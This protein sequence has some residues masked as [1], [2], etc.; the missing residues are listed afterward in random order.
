MTIHAI[1]LTGL[2]NTAKSFRNELSAFM[3]GATS[4]RPTGARSGVRFGTPTNT[5]SLSGL[6]GSS[7]Y[8]G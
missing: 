6:T 4:A 1:A 8:G 5:V 2:E 7:R 3:F